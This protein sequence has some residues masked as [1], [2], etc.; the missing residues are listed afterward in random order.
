MKKLIF[1]VLIAGIMLLGASQAQAVTTSSM[2]ASDVS[3][4][5]DVE[6][7]QAMVKSLMAQIESMKGMRSDDM[8]TTNRLKLERGFKMGEEGD[9]VRILQKI[10]SSDPSVY[11][12]GRQT[13]YFGELTVKALTRFQEKNGLTVTGELDEETRAAINTFLEEAKVENENVPSG[14]LSREDLRGKMK[15]RMMMRKDNMM[16]MKMLKEKC[17]D[18]EEDYCDKLENLKNNPPKPIGKP[19]ILNSDKKEVSSIEVEI[20]GKK[21]KVEVEIND[22]SKKFTTTFSTEENL[23]EKLAKKFGLSV[24]DVEDMISYEYED[25]DDEDE[26]DSD[27]DN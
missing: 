17:D 16:H 3:S 13:G 15:D 2:N 9:G 12:E 14:L 5:T 8:S 10:L 7:L 24:N 6:K 21:A 18:G 23:E 4:V 20:D 22:K 27:D 11:P 26:D 1:P 19:K 25:S